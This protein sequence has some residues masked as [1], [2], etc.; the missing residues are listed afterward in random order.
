[1]SPRIA[2]DRYRSLLAAI[3]HGSLS[4]AARALG[5][6]Q[7]TVGRHIAELERAF[8]LPLFT[9]SPTGLLPTPAALALMPFARAMASSEAAL[10]RAADGQQEGGRGDEDSVRGTVRVTASEV[11]GVEVMPAIL[12]SLRER[13]PALRIELVLSN[14]LQDLLHREA[15]LAVRMT[16]P[17]QEQLLARKVGDLQLGLFAH[18]RYLDARGAPRG[19]DQLAAHALIGYDAETPFVRSMS[20]QWPGIGRDDFALRADSNLVQLALIRAGAGIGVCQVSLA[21]RDPA[22]RRVLPKKIGWL[23]PT[24]ITMHEDLRHSARCRVVFDALH[25]GL[26]RHLAAQAA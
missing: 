18:R 12:A 15:D 19:V 22:L 23:L 3:E 14:Q 9:R 11:I 10:R 25:E 8:R 17:T 7:P 21:R 24:W 4:E 16:A 2:W 1:M 13:H 26:A 5:S 20:G 6:T